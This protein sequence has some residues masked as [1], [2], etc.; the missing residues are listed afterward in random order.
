MISSYPDAYGEIQKKICGD[1]DD[2]RKADGLWHG[3]EVDGGVGHP[4]G[5]Q[6]KRGKGIQWFKDHK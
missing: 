5:S 3:V 6:I 1:D 2:V 4:Q